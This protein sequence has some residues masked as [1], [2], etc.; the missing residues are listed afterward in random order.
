MFVDDNPDASL[1]EILAH[2][3]VLGMKWGKHRAKGNSIDVRAA[4]SRTF[5]AN[6]NLEQQQSKAQNIRD[7]KKRA[8]ALKDVEKQRVKNL[9]NPDRVLAAR[10]TRGEKAA[11][12]LLLT[13]MGA[14]ALIAATSAHSRRIERKQEKGKYDPKKK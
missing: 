11:S 1:D 4:R 13:P 5:T 14:G 3:G 12:A 7:P 2:H 8:A 9:K 10:L 6:H